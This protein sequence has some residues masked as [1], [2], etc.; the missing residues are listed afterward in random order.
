MLN[1]KDT[2]QNEI[3]KM[4]LNYIN[5]PHKVATVSR[6]EMH[7]LRLDGGAKLIHIQSKIANRSV[8]INRIRKA[9]RDYRA[10]LKCKHQI[11]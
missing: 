2:T 1:I 6:Q 5:Y 11:L 9:Y 7:K 3:L 4:F 8:S 10:G